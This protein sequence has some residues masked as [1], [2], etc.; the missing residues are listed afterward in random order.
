[1]PQLTIQQA[2]DL[3]LRHYHA[4]Q[5]GE[6]ELVCRQILVQQPEQ[7]EAMHLLGLI[8]RRAGKNDI[9]ADLIR[10]AI[11][12]KPGCAE[13][14]YNLGNA[15]RDSGH[16]DQ[17]IAAYGE[18]IALN[19]NYAE[20]H[21]HLGNALR[22]NGQIDQAIAVLGRAIAV[23]PDLAEAHNNLAIALKDRRQLDEAVAACR[24]AIA[25]RPDF[26]AAHCNLGNLFKDQGQLDEA[27][28]AYRA[29]LALAPENFSIGSD[30]V[31]A[32]HFH[33]AYDAG[34]IAG[35]H[36]RWNRRHAEPLASEIPPHQNDRSATR[37]LRV[38]Y[39]SPDFREHV[40]GRNL[41]PLFLQ[42]DHQQFEITCYS[43]LRRPDAM[44]SR[45]QENADCWRNIAG[46]TDAQAAALVRQDRIDILVDLTLHMANN[47]LLVFARKPAPVQVTYLGYCG[48]T[49]LSTM[50]YRLSDPYLDPV[51]SLTLAQGRPVDVAQGEAPSADLS[52]CSE[53]T[54]RLPRTYWCYH[55]GGPAPDP[56][57]PPAVQNGFVTF[58]C[59][60]NFAKVSAPAIDLWARI[61]AELPTSRMIIHSNAGKHPGHAVRRF[62]EGGV[63][64]NRL[65][66]I[67][68]Q[69]WPG[70]VAAYSQIDIA[71]DPFPHGGGITTCDALWMGVPVVTL[72]GQTP[73]GRGGRSIL[74]N[75]G[76]PELIAFTPEQ[77]VQIATDLARD[78]DLLEH[79][80]LGMRARMRA[81]PLMDAAQFARDM[82]SAYRR[83]WRTWCDSGRLA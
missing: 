33:P 78:L 77:Y 19:P 18:A 62:E 9:A 40:V 59:L 56:S 39:L 22:E 82:E 2:L 50:D 69:P 75:L 28:A 51:D 8:A 74:S 35:E 23:N 41:L 76:L 5:L 48:T 7:M 83:M 68:A 24:R 80:R 43:N 44:T 27:I 36:R 38:G 20:A 30:L 55:P 71:L 61:L 72:S 15:L 16:L 47:R 1:M 17:C 29:G 81:S 46:L 49:G 53:K 3:A 25:L 54:V 65:Q 32:L 42:H 60:N 4:G 70:Y 21:N 34:A 12:L 79:L 37:R 57:P 45:F 26:A 63:T 14:H 67:G 64:R 52:C 10:R 66:F 58:G 6:A 31:Y 11:V 13:A 73:V